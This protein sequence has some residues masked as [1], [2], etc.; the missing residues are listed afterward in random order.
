MQLKDLALRASVLFSLILSVP[1]HAQ[2]AQGL[3]SAKDTALPIGAGGG[4]YL[5]IGT[6][7]IVD[8]GTT[9]I[10]ATPV[11]V[12]HAS[13]NAN[14]GAAS[15]GGTTVTSFVDSGGATFSGNV[16]IGTP[17]PEPYALLTVYDSGAN[18]NLGYSSG[19]GI[20]GLSYGVGTCGTVPGMLF[21]ASNNLIFNV[22]GNAS[23]SFRINNNSQPSAFNIG[24]NGN[25]GINNSTPQTTLDVNGPI[26]PGSQT[27]GNGCSPTGA[28]GRDSIGHTLNCL[29]G[30]WS[31][32]PTMNSNSS[33]TVSVTQT[34][35]GSASNNA[36]S[37]YLA[38]GA[39]NYGGN[40]YR[41]GTVKSHMSCVL[42][43]VQFDGRDGGC[44]MG[45]S[46][47]GT[48]WVEADNGAGASPPALSYGTTNCQMTCYDF[49]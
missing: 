29:A 25:V 49:Q 43:S 36:G 7:G 44:S 45:E 37:I 40:Y 31:M 6:A 38:A 48:W 34:Y 8:I 35:N 27:V 10:G 14:T 11:F 26:L 17:S 30:T 39:N 33:E 16:G 42:T 20:M 1:V 22:P 18:L 15:F 41:A 9:A 46:P 2:T 21:D 19:C 24:T 32:V 28:I 12:P 23:Y 3:N 13:I 4:Q 47:G 5:S